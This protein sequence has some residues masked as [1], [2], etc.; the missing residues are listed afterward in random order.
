MGSILGCRNAALAMAAGMSGTR[1][2]FLRFDSSTNGMSKS[3]DVEIDA[4]AEMKQKNVLDERATF[5]KSV[6]K[7]DHAYIALFIQK[8]KSIPNVE[9][10]RFCDS[11]GLSY[12][13]MKE[14]AQLYDQL[15][16]SLNAAGFS[17][18]TESNINSNSWRIVQACAVA[19]MAP[20]QLVK[21]QR[22][23]A[24]YSETS[25]GAVAKDGEARE[26]K[27][28]IRTNTL[29]ETTSSIDKEQRVYI[30]PSS[31]NFKVG[32]YNCPFLV[33]NSL[34]T[35]SKPFLRDITE[36][37]TYAMLLF[38][39]PIEVQAS[40]GILVID[41]WAQLSANARIGTLVGGL[42]KRVDSLLLSKISNPM[43][44]LSSTVEMKIIVQ[45]IKTDGLGA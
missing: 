31:I 19:A 9:H 15:D 21:V 37:S 4:I 40:K 33:Y 25:E 12:P 11:L 24:K 27:F 14:I 22:P 16:S 6:G 3:K 18:T 43:T 26:L 44:E 35:T 42:R 38:G 28:F 10:N 41:G 17:S 1:S 30:H 23:A 7:S 45:L 20:G 29:S 2:P 5:L 36:C 34:V 8:W 39:G 13:V 32:N